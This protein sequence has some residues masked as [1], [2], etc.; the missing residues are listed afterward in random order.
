MVFQLF[1]YAYAV[2]SIKA[3]MANS[4]IVPNLTTRFKLS[5]E[6]KPR[7]HGEGNNGEGDGLG[8]KSRFEHR[9]P[10]STLS[11]SRCRKIGA[12]GQRT[13]KEGG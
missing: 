3:T 7:G 9:D 4:P 13:D 11:F 8:I 5:V 10:T 1:D 2:I 12:R 6:E